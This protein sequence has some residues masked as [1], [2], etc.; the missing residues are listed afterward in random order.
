MLIIHII[1]SWFEKPDHIPEARNVNC[2][3]YQS[4]WVKVWRSRYVFKLP[5]YT[6]MNKK[7]NPEDSWKICYKIALGDMDFAMKWWFPFYSDKTE[8]FLKEMVEIN[9]VQSDL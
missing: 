4:F 2:Y 5:Y 1:K 7:Y 8:D 9:E 3:Q 6:W